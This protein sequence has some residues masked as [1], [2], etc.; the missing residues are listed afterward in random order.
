[1]LERILNKGYPISLGVLALA[2]LIGGCAPEKKTQANRP[3]PHWELAWKA[4][5]TISSPFD[6][7]T[8]KAWI[9]NAAALSGQKELLDKWIADEKVPWVRITCEISR[10]YAE[11]L[12]GKAEKRKEL[13]QAIVQETKEIDEWEQKRISKPLMKANVAICWQGSQDIQLIKKWMSGEDENRILA[14]SQFLC[15]WLTLLTHG[16]TN[17]VACETNTIPILELLMAQRQKRAPFEQLRL[18]AQL[19]PLLRGSQWDAAV[20]EDTVKLE[21]SYDKPDCQTLLDFSRIYAGLGKKEKAD[22]LISRAQ[23]M[24]EA[25]DTGECLAPWAALAEAKAA[26][27]RDSA[28]VAQAFELGIQ[29]SSDRPGYFKPVAEALT[30]AM[31]AQHETLA[32]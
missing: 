8:T 7:G 6:V 25:K 15:D 1:M 21:Q 19:S 16:A 31:R 29:R 20:Q 13:L 23:A 17:G 28:E 22:E 14:A 18:L 2:V 4:A 9:C 27:G 26:A 3:N 5:N 30:Y 11:A 12:F 24:I 10:A 32:K